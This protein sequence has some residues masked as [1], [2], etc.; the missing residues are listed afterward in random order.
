MHL[1]RRVGV[2]I[3]V[4]EDKKSNWNDTILFS[5]PRDDIVNHNIRE[6]TENIDSTKCSFHTVFLII[7]DVFNILILIILSVYIFTDSLIS[8]IF[9]KVNF[10]NSSQNE[11]LSPSFIAL[12]FDGFGSISWH[13]FSAL[14]Q[15]SKSIRISNFFRPEHHCIKIGTY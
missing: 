8:V 14:L 6:T 7:A 10:I 13:S 4:F 9:K 12:Y 11:V 15:F 5:D 1:N 2:I 3:Y